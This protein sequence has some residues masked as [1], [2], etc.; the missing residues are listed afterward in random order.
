[1]TSD[2]PLTIV[3]GYLGAGKTTLINH[4]LRHNQGVRLAVLVNEFGALPIDADLIEGQSETIISI[5]GGCI[6]CSF[7]DD[8]GAALLELQALK[9]RPDHILIEASGVALPGAIA[10]TIDLYQGIRLEGVVVL[11]DCETIQTQADNE[12]IGDTIT[13]QLLDAGLVVLTKSDLVENEARVPLQTWIGAQA[14]H[15]AI[16]F[17][18]NGQVPSNVILG[19]R[20]V[21]VLQSSAKPADAFFESRNFDASQPIDVRRLATDLASEELGL[22]R[23][24][25]CALGLDHQKHVLQVVGR[26]WT[27]EQAPPDMPTGIVCIGYRSNFPH[28]QLT[29]LG[30]AWPLKSS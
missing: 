30:L 2:L 14:P 5:S 10:A 6:C 27:L 21:P 12:Y 25:G 7:G 11:A 29:A 3:G 20:S 24:K 18:S 9:P 16:V 17:S 15:A 4:M 26:R 28:A 19:P 1:M 23:A 22:V 8:L 13:R